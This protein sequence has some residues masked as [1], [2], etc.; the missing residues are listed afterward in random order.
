MYTL[1]TLFANYNVTTFQYF[2][3]DVVVAASW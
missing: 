2:V 3:Y 1:Y